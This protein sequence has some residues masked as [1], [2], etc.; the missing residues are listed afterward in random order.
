VSENSSF[1]NVIISENLETDN[2]IRRYEV[3]KSQDS[4]TGELIYELEIV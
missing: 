4:E 3:V 1:V 2:Y